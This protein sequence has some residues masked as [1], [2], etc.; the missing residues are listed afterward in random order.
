MPERQRFLRQQRPRR[1]EVRCTLISRRVALSIALW[2]LVAHHHRSEALL[3]R[4][5]IQALKA[6]IT[7]SH[8]GAYMGRAI[9]VSRAAVGRAHETLYFGSERS[10]G[11][12]RCLRP[13]LTW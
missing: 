12:Y 2:Q 9:K 5:P 11:L 7:A 13:V 1:D 10:D 8:V 6:F 4:H 3:A